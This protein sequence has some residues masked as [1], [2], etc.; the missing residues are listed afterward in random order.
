MRGLLAI[1]LL[2]VAG[3]ASATEPPPSC[4][5]ELGAASVADRLSEL[6][7]EIQDDLVRIAGGDIGESNAPL[8]QTDAPS[9]AE[10]GHA[11]ARFVHGLLVD[12]EWFVQIEIAMTAGVR[13]F[14][15]VED[16]RGIFRRRV[17]HYFGGP[18]CASIVAAR[19]GVYNPGPAPP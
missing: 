9:A 15:Y 12:R 8:L 14:G 19:A 5:V 3:A 4:A 1:G 13:T 16:D 18:A 6:P 11:T 17:A 2:Q 10:K 7:R